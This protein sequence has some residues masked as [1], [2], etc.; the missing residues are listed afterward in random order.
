MVLCTTRIL[1][2][3]FAPYELILVCPVSKPGRRSSKGRPLYRK[4]LRI[5]KTLMGTSYGRSPY[6][7]SVLPSAA[8]V[9]AAVVSPLYF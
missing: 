2:V 4:A 9:A 1:P 5:A 3:V 7:N 8:A 6:K